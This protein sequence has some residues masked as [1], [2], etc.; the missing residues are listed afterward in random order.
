MMINTNNLKL[1]GALEKIKE[2]CE[3]HHSCFDCPLHV[4]GLDV[5]NAD[6]HINMCSITSSINPACWN[7]KY[8]AIRREKG[9][10]IKGYA[11]D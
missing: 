1:L 10:L 2:E 5:D 11:K 7:L 8:K 4:E 3:L 9:V 6:E